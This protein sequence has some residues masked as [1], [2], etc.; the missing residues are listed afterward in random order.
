M[1]GGGGGMQ[2]PQRVK[3]GKKSNR[4]K[5]NRLNFA[6]VDIT[7][8]LLTFFLFTTTMLKPQIMEMKI[9]PEKIDAGDDVKVKASELFNIFVREDGKL[10]YQYGHADGTMSDPESVDIKKLGE[11]AIKQNLRPDIG[12]NRLISVLKADPMSKYEVVVNVLN[13]L[14]LAEVSIA[15]EISKETDATTGSPLERRRK[16]TFGKFTEEDKTLIKDL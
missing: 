11:V 12:K 16:F 14:N 2:L 6:V 9:P 3:R 10:F 8:L 7:L 5:P 13:E 1:A 15:T 4:K